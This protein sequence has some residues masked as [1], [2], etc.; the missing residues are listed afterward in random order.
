MDFWKWIAGALNVELTSADICGFLAAVQRAQVE[1]RD[2]QEAGPFQIRFQIQRQAWQ[3]VARIAQRRGDTLK[4]KKSIGL[5]WTINRLRKRPVLVIGL[6]IM[7]L[8]SAWAPSRVFF[9]RVEGNAQVPSRRILECAA[10]C[11]ISFGASRRQVRS[12]KMKNAL[13]DAMPALS[14][15][16]VNTYGCTAV[17]SVQERKEEETREQ[18]NTV[19]SIVASRDGVIQQVTV[20]QGNKL[21]SVGQAVKKGQVLI[22]GYTDCGLSIQATNAKGEIFA[23]TNRQFTV[24]SPIAY[25]LREEKTGLTQKI[26]LIIGNKRINFSNSSGISGAGCAKIYEENYIVL[27]G[28]FQLPIAICIETWI[29]YDTD[30]DLL[31]A[32]AQNLSAFSGQYLLSQMLA[33]SIYHADEQLAEHEDILLLRGN[34]NCLEMIG[35]TRLE[36]KL[37]EYVEN[38]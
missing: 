8:F 10:E 1:L 18:Q 27:P 20:L 21:C 19:S 12:E 5:Y 28:G 3:T 13:L 11:G 33:G 34:Y 25:C 7:F 14:W 6:L 32:D 17:I 22:S 2:L 35:I 24:I 15:A 29:S 4:C 26:S 31:A 36:E 9:V 30:E 38:D 16:G 37:L 23:H